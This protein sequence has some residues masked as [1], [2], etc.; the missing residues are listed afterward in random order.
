MWQLFYAS[1]HTELLPPGAQ[2]LVRSTRRPQQDVV[3]G[4]WQQIMDRPIGETTALIDENLAAL[5]TTGVPY[6]HIAGHEPGTDYRQW[7]GQ[8]LPAA[9]VD[10]W[11]GSGHFPHLADPGRFTRRLA[12]TGRWAPA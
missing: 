1:F 3:L 4:Y 9:A 5:R 7:L 6:L 10:V 11:P 8:R 2:E 12:A